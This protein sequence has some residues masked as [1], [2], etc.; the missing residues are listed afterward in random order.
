MR[1]PFLTALFPFVL[2]APTLLA[3][4]MAR[5]SDAEHVC[6]DVF[7]ANPAW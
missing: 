1:S 2:G 5:S 7:T 3:Q 6:P 4:K